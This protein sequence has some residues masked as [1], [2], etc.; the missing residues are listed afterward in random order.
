MNRRTSMRSSPVTS[1]AMAPLGGGQGS[2]QRWGGVGTA[3]GT[4]FLGSSKNA[5]HRS[6]IILW[7][8][9]PKWVSSRRFTMILPPVLS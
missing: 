7:L 3:T 5:P 1:L 4:K 8:V 6:R 2:P 9:L